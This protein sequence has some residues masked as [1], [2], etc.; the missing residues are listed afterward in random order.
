MIPVMTMR[1]ALDMYAQI[2]PLGH[3]AGMSMSPQTVDEL[4]GEM[5]KDDALVPFSRDQRQRK[6]EERC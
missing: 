4:G 6:D 1:M 3:S 5:Q 2:R